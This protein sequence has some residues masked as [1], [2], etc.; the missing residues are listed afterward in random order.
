MRADTAACGANDLRTLE[1]NAYCEDRLADDS[2]LCRG[3]GG[4]TE[5]HAKF[6]VSV[7][8]PTLSVAVRAIGA[9][10]YDQ[11]DGREK[12]DQADTEETP[13]QGKE[14]PVKGRISVACKG[15]VGNNSA[16]GRSASLHQD[17]VE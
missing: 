10:R 1:R 17:A 6:A 4:A 15:F 2:D 9:Q 11:R 3:A 14:L 13:A 16:T 8:V 7:I 12:R 5:V